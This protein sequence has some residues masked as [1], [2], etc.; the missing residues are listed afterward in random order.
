M[1]S[2]EVG[3]RVLCIRNHSKGLYKRGSIYTLQGIKLGCQHFPKLLDV[4]I[5]SEGTSC[6]TCNVSLGR[7]ILWCASE[8]FVPYDD[9]LSELT[10]DMI[11]DEILKGS[12]VL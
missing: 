12:E 3:R 4:G 9:E 11:F 5:D 2:F 7:G 8:S 1:A 6:Y 10:T